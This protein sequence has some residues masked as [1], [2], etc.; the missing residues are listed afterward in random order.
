MLRSLQGMRAVLRD[1][2]RLVIESRNW[3]KLHADAI[4]F[5][6]FGVRERQGIR[7]IPL[8]I[9]NF[10]RDFQ[11]PVL[12]EVVLVFEQQGQVRLQTHS[13][14]Y[15]PFHADRLGSLLQQ[16]GFDNVENNWTPQTP[17]Y[18]IVAKACHPPPLGNCPVRVDR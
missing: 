10:G 6:H 14:T 8:Y 18:R 3:E 13:I 7:C 15:Q 9:W 5:T 2:G 4:R 12:V 11:E 1:G 17:S 16:A